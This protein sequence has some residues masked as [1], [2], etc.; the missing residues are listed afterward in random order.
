VEVAAPNKRLERTR[1]LTAS[2]PSFLGEPLKRIYRASQAKKER[3]YPKGAEGFV[4]P[5]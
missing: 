5:T 1:Q 2:I 3:T 4:F